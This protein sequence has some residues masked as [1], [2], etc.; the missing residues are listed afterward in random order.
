MRA[1][2]RRKAGGRQRART[3]DLYGVNGRTSCR[4]RTFPTLLY[5]EMHQF[6]PE[7]RKSAQDDMRKL[8][9]M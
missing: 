2:T 8:R 5:P 1:E 6:T 9:Y 3:S 4:I 7:V